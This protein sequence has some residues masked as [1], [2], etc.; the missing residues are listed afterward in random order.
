MF[1][2]TVLIGI[3]SM[4]VKVHEFLLPI[5]LAQQSILPLRAPLRER[6]GPRGTD[7]EGACAVLL[8]PDWFVV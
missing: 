8:C 2:A 4:I 7:A 3:F 1:R 5:K 6:A